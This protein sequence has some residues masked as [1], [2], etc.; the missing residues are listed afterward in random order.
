MQ[1]TDLAKPMLILKR[2]WRREDGKLSVVRRP[3]GL[4]L[5]C[6]GLASFVEKRELPDDVVERV[7]EV[8][9]DVPDDET[10]VGWSGGTCDLIAVAARL[11][12]RIFDDGVRISFLAGDVFFEPGNVLFCPL[13]LAA[14]AV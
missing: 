7:V 9:D 2:L 3:V 11:R 1:A 6:G 8:V 14:R 10:P 13:D 12:L 4:L 5:G